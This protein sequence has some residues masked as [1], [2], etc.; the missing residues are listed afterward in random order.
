MSN[1]TS[2]TD[3]LN[4]TTDYVYDDFNRLKKIKYPEA[5]VE[6]DA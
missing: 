5:T 6:Q 2:V 4:R 3:A 1:L